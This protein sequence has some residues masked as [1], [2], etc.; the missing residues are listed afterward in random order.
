MEAP[1]EAIDF[2]G[3]DIRWDRRV[4]RPR[5]WTAQQSRW[6]AELA[7]DAPDGPI[8]E[9][10]CGAGHIGLL[11]AQLTGRDLVQV[12]RDPV[13]ASYA[14]RNAERAGISADVRSAAL[15]S[16]LRP[17]ERFGLVIADPP[18]LPTGT[19]A[20][21]PDD[22][23]LAVDGG[24]DGF[25]MILE[26]LDTS[27]RQLLPEGHLLLQVGVPQQAEQV[28]EWLDGHASGRAVTDVRDC[29]PG[30]LLL[31]VGPDDSEEGRR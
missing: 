12:D 18:W 30:G 8:L 3:L 20:Q 31:H 27:L 26:C 5:P 11:A 7:E 2:A 25:D 21:Y 4:L 29:R 10:C 1:E 19:V 22:P 23:V 13:A 28:T 6:A 17:D 24:A 14:R 16:A 9:L 15:R